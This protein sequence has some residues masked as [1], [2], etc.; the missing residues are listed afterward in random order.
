MNHDNER[1]S[2]DIMA[3][4]VSNYIDENILTN[5]IIEK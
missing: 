1:L 3:T 4:L 2:E 5:S